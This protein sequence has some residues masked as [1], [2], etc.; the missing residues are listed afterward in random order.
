MEN[1]GTKEHQQN[2]M[3]ALEHVRRA[4]ALSPEQASVWQVFKEM[5]D[6]KMAAEHNT[7]WGKLFVEI[8]LEIL[9]AIL[10]V[11]PLAVGV[12]MEHERVKLWE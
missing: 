5:W 4:A 9:H 11:D 12:W 2:R 10:Y 3:A 8:V 7:L 1:G 6:A